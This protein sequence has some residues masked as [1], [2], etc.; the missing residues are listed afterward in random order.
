MKLI[1][2]GGFKKEKPGILTN[3]GIRRDC[4]AFFS[5]WNYDFFQN[6]GLNK[7][8]GMDVQDFPVVD[9][10]IRWGAPIARPGKVVCIGLN[11]M[12]HIKETGASIP[13]EPLIFMKGTNSVIGPYDNI[14]IPKNST[15][16]D[17]EIELGVIIKKDC[18]YLNSEAEAD[19]YIAGYTISHDV[20]ERDFQK[21]H[22]G[23]WCKG[24]SCD[25]FNPVGPFLATSDEIKDVSNLNMCLS[26]NGIKRQNSNTKMMIFNPRFLVHYL[27]QFMTL[28]A[29]DLLST[30][31]PHGV[32]MGMK[33]QTFLKDGDT[34][35]LKIE[36]LGSQK[37][38]C[39]DLIHH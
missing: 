15:K 22:G 25:T 27:S 10:T 11:Y 24:K 35:E 34:V 37:Q 13:K 36:G 20:S 19:D 18:R 8:A 9:E 29:G 21:E 23:Q 33:P 38:I 28:E 31:T 5:D 2:F 1:R 32:G 6:D 39:K 26:V 4:S 14:L 30:G 16:T 17:W 3:D 7:L 12:D